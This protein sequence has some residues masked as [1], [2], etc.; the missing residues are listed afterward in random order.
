MT[1]VALSYGHVL[2]ISDP[3]NTHLQ[4]KKDILWYGLILALA[5]VLLR[6]LEYRALL[7]ESPFHFGIILL[8]ILF[9][10]AGVWLGTRASGAKPSASTTLPIQPDPPAVTSEDLGIS[11]RE[12]EVLAL[13]IAGHSNQEIA[14]QLH[15]SITTVKS[16]VSSIYQKLDVQRRTQAVQKARQLGLTRYE[17]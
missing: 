9:L 5:L 2:Y 4:V 7:W 14:D 3:E 17:V 11:R 6:W 1:G 13:I 15:I 16:H 10:G 8:A 12:Q